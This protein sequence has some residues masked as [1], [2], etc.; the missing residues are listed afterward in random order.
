[1]QRVPPPWALQRPLERTSFVYPGMV[2][3]RL[4]LSGSL[5]ARVA[6]AGLTTA[7]APAAVCLDVGDAGGGRAGGRVRG[8]HLGR[9]LPN[10]EAATC[11]KRMK[12]YT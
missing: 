9:E 2:Q 3:R 8:L 6:A 4:G 11:L 1:M 12:K 7:V 10:N 5:R